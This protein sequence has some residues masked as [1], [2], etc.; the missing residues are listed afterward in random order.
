MFFEQPVDTADN[1]GPQAVCQ[2]FKD[3]ALQAYQ[4]EIENRKQDIEEDF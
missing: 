2:Q 3:Y 1:S 4:K